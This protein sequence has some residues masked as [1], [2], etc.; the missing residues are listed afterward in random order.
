MVITDGK[1]TSATEDEMYRLYLNSGYDD[2]F[3]FREY[4]TRMA[5]AGCEITQ[6]AAQCECLKGD[7][8][9]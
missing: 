7:S 8:N 4:K 6:A 2:C 3:D 1:I 9:A 5:A